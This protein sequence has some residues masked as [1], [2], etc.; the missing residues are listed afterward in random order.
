MHGKAIHKFGLVALWWPFGPSDH[1][2]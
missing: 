1:S 2:A